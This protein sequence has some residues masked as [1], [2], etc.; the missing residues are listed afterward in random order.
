MENFIKG[1]I[2]DLTG[3]IVIGNSRAFYTELTLGYN[4]NFNYQIWRSLYRQ[5]SSGVI[6]YSHFVESLASKL[7]IPPAELELK[8]AASVST[9]VRIAKGAYEVLLQVKRLGLRSAIL[10]NNIAEWVG[11][12][13][14]KLNFGNF[15]DA[16]LVSSSIKVRK[17][18]ARAYILASIAIDR[19]PQDLCYVGDED[20]DV[21]GA[22][23]VGMKAVFIP[24]EDEFSEYCDYMIRNIGEVLKLP[25][26]QKR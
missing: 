19:I 21:R 23:K 20:G 14:R 22:K 5:A 12:I 18:S 10:T 17:P 16:I 26:L 25:L 8:I 9:K 1:I 2:F 4:L 13:E 6:T 24:G 7:S 15:V 11:I 3:V